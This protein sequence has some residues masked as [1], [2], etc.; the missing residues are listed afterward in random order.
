MKRVF[1]FFLNMS[2][3]FSFQEELSEIW[4]KMYISLH[5]KYRRACQ[6]LINPGFSEQVFEEYWKIKVHENHSSGKELFHA[7][8]RTDRH[9]DRRNDR[10]G[11]ANIH[12]S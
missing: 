7:G 9:T 2:E 10:Y 8:G 11:E 3:P 12:F 1:I 6:I 4:S 5:V